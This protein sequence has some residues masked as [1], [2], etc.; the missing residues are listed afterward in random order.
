MKQ[1]KT[2]GR[3]TK[4]WIDVGPD[5]LSKI[6]AECQR[7]GKCSRAAIVRMALARWVEAS[8]PTNTPQQVA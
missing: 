4:V 3:N 2:T 1:R 8:Q 7:H 5:M 6:D